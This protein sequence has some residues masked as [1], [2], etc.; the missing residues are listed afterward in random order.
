MHN[1]AE[2][3]TLQQGTAADA[4]DF[5]TNRSADFRNV[6]DA[7]HDAIA[8]AA[9]GENDNHP[10]QKQGTAADAADCETNSASGEGSLSL[11][12]AE[13]IELELPAGCLQL[14]LRLIVHDPPMF[15]D[16]HR[17]CTTNGPSLYA[18]IRMVRPELCYALEEGIKLP[19][20]SA[21]QAIQAFIAAL[22]SWM[23]PEEL[24]TV[25][26]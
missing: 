13:R 1:A 3:A 22:V 20:Y 6:Q 19:G 8:A 24:N 5:E 11:P 2:N 23:S 12:D 21:H 10:M 18:H 7:K 25:H 16:S 9:A 15:S 17:R 14:L 26:Q 4:A